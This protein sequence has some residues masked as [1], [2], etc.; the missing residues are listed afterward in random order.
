MYMNGSRSAS[1]VSDIIC[2]SDRKIVGF[3]PLKQVYT[4][5]ACHFKRFPSSAPSGKL[6]G[7]TLFDLF[8]PLKHTKGL[9][10]KS[11]KA[12]KHHSK[13]LVTIIF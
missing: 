2:L 10:S 9:K 12:V 3:T 7:A 5:K 1:N 8:I 6:T 4:K 13:H 11:I